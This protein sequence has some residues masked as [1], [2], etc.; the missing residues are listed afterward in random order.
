M[1]QQ[2]INDEIKQTLEPLAS[3]AVLQQVWSVN[4]TS[5]KAKAI[6]D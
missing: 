5:T 6:L 1:H 4:Y 3:V 2:G